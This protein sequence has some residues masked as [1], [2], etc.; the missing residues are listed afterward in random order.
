MNPD[1]TAGGA[2]DETNPPRVDEHDMETPVHK[3]ADEDLTHV[4]KSED[5]A[6]DNRTPL[7]LLLKMAA[8]EQ[9][10]STMA[11]DELRE[12]L[13]MDNKRSQVNA[14]DEDG[15][16]AL[17]IATQHGLLDAAQELIDAEADVSAKA[18][19]GRQP[20]HEACLGG[21]TKL[22]SL[23]LRNGADIEAKGEA[24]TTPLDNA[25]FKGHIEVVRL[26]LSNHARVLVT[27][28]NGWSPLFTANKS[29][30]LATDKDGWSP[31]YGASRYGH[32]EI[33]HALLR[34]DKSNILATNKDGW[35]PL[36]AASRYGHEGIV[37]TLLLADKSNINDPEKTD[38]WTPL[39]GATFHGHEKIVSLLLE[40]GAGLGAKDS[41][42]WTPLMAATGQQHARIMEM[43]LTPRS[44][45][46]DIQLETPDD[47]GLTPLMVA[48]KDGF[49]DGVRQLIKAGANCNAQ[50]GG[51]T[52]LLA[53]SSGRH[54]EIVKV[55]LEPSCRTNVNAQNVY[56]QTALHAASAQN[57]IKVVQLLLQHKADVNLKDEDGRSALHLACIRGN[58]TV[59]KMLL[60]ERATLDEKDN[61]EKTALHLASSVE[62]DKQR[63]PDDDEG[64][65][66]LTPEE[67]SNAK[68]QSGRHA[69][70]V[71]LLLTLG[72]DPGARTNKNETAAHLAAARGDP[73]RLGHILQRMKQED[74]SA[75]NADGRTALYMAFKGEEPETAMKSLLELVNVK[76]CDFGEHDAWHEALEWAAKDPNT[77][78]IAKWL[79]Q[80]RERP[81]V[82]TQPLGSDKWSAIEWAAHERLPQTLWTLITVSDQSSQ[83][84]SAVLSALELVKALRTPAQRPQHISKATPR[85]PPH[86]E[87]NE[88][89]KG[90]YK[91]KGKT[92]HDA[93][94]TDAKQKGAQSKDLETM[95]DIL[96]NLPFLQTHKHSKEYGLPEPKAGLGDMLERFQATVVQF[97]EAKDESGT[98]RRCRPVQ[99]VI[100]DA[101]P[102]S[103][104]ETA[105]KFLVSLGGED[106]KMLD[107]FVHPG[108]ETKFTWM[109]WMNDLLTRIMK[110]EKR[111][112]RQYDEVRS[113]FRDSWS[114]LPDKTSPSRIMKPRTV[115]RQE[116][117]SVPEKDEPERAHDFLNA[118]AIYMPFF[119]F[120]SH[121]RTWL[122]LDEDHEKPKEARETY[123]RLLR[124]YKSSVVHRLPTLDEWY[125]HFAADKKSAQDR[126]N[127]NETQVVTKFTKTRESDET[128]RPP[129][130]GKRAK[131]TQG[132]ESNPTKPSQWTLLRVNQ[133]WVWIVA[134]KW[135]LTATSCS[136]D[137]SHDE[138]VDGILTQLNNQ[139][140]YGGSGSQPKSVAEM[141]KLIVEYCIGSYENP[142]K[143]KGQVSIRQTFSHYLNKIV[144]RS[145]ELDNIKSA[146]K[147]AEKL[148]CDIKDVRDELNILKSAA[149]YQMIVQRGL[150]NSPVEDADLSATYVVNDLRE[151]DTF[152]DR[153]QSA[154][155]TTLSLQQS[156]IANFQASLATDQGKVVMAFTFATLLFC[157]SS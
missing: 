120:S 116:K 150:A 82:A 138:L 139:A 52:P 129:Q 135:I 31:L 75:R 147:E 42:G 109:D 29:N 27:D 45:D 84:R 97:Y 60:D 86:R 64:P 152:A 99:E 73:E 141:A 28:E 19:S 124:A 21:H 46:E 54:R 8:E 2:L 39:H 51:T 90:R 62:A 87:E 48:S 83:V 114:E 137:D 149:Q 107:H 88:D 145:P 142:P 67:R 11:L 77:H 151:M 33:V 85:A 93:Q 69:A 38:T 14:Q 50:S 63:D 7:Q 53:A 103:I 71:Q 10:T 89:E 115:S 24:Q 101:G 4:R 13:R 156:E 20:L 140:K 117:A 154:V 98:I 125:Y 79:L 102:T 78:D 41:D 155:N 133:L 37:R 23:L 57:N 95:E 104:M 76:T 105:A 136:F 34:E 72:A 91:G 36:N 59:A 119:C 56:R 49:L 100:Y 5:Q 130:S 110:D 128:A 94:Q 9:S 3:S 134:N 80:K 47:E 146:I 70:V 26:L 96:R 113:F 144:C 108:T 35:S 153:I 92:D 127:R 132:D 106:Q 17:H 123:K 32:E 44:K 126:Q 43:L 15:Q 40:N 16:T 118:S 58:E 121:R 55:L 143:A 22:A 25:C 112:P 61:D 66:D 18:I 68:F 74:L 111:E 122:D 1:E 81:A 6:H 12:L 65:D 148:Y 30:I 131:L 157:S